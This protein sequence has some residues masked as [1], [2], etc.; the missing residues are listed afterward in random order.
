[1]IGR[2]G[3][4]A[5]PPRPR[6]RGPGWSAA[7]TRQAALLVL[8]AGAAPARR[9]ALRRPVDVVLSAGFQL[10]GIAAARLGGGRVTGR[11]R[12]RGQAVDRAADQEHAGAA[13]TGQP[14]Q[15][16]LQAGAVLVPVR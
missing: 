9:V 7:A 1:M 10:A 3:V 16:L 15:F 11:P 12:E 8:E 14:D 13:D 4:Q 2:T 5:A 6:W